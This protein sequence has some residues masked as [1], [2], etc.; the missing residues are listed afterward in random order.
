MRMLAADGEIIPP[1]SFIAASERFGLIS[2]IDRWVVCQALELAADGRRLEINLSAHSLG[3]REIT[4][5]VASAV[6]HGVDPENLVFEITETAA[7]AN[8]RAAGDFA[9]RLSRIGCGFALDDFGTGF[10]SL[11]YLKHVPFAYL[12]IDTEFVRDLSRDRVSQRIVRAV[13]TIASHLSQKT[14]A[15]GVEDA[16][17]LSLLRALGVDLAQGYHIARPGPLGSHPPGPHELLPREAA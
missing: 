14:I 4:R 7:A 15:E 8:Y 16:A 12:K 3:D 1:A 2:E 13:V 17:T 9:E 11:T 10:G 5:M 6:D